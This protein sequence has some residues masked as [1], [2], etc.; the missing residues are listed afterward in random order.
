MSAIEV[1]MD[2]H[3][4]IERALATLTAYARGVA[5]GADLPRPDLAG[6]V[7]FLREYADAHHHG[8]EEDILFRA[9]VDNGMPE[10]S[11]PLAVMLSEH[12]EG[13][14]L[15]GVLA[16]LA[17][18]EAEWDMDE[19]RRLLFAATGYARLLGEHIQKE[20]RVLYPM[21]RHMLPDDV[22]R[23]IESEFSAF[24]TAPQRAERADHL[25]GIVR[26]LADRYASEDDSP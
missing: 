7:S 19:R 26:E 21:A 11:G 20:D 10:D 22:W 15:T 4:V 14:R 17:V 24:S 25:K 3:R 23:G 6:L 2:E 18:G 12:T 13:R 9:M 1:L 8:K 16:E 5:N